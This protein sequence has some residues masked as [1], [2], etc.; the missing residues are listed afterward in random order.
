MKSVKLWFC[1]DDGGDGSVTPRFF[2]SKQDAEEAEEKEVWGESSI[3]C[4]NLIIKDGEICLQKSEYDRDTG[5][6][7]YITSV[8]S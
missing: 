6:V 3:G 4:V 8:L 2:N 5:K 7:A 1:V